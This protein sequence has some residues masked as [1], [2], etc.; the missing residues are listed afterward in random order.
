[1]TEQHV[2]I[3]ELAAYAAGDLDA[4]AAVAVEA[5][6]VL[7]AQC[8]ADVAGLT[9]TAAA[10]ASVPP[11]TM[12]AAAVARLDAA[13]LAE[14]M[15]NRRAGDVVPIAGRRRPTFGGIAAVAAGVALLA[16][17]GVPLL[18]DTTKKAGSSAP[19]AARDLAAGPARSSRDASRPAST[20]PARTSPP[21]SSRPSTAPSGSPPAAAP[22]RPSPTLPR[23]ARWSP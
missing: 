7:C 10:L 6:V 16:A 22:A 5:H 2:P 13:L 9:A 11:V 21:P 23:R 18:R 20:T 19:T 15:P 12:P 3:E 1:M 17:I 8:G 14:A 4:T